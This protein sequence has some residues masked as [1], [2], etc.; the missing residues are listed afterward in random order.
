M[1]NLFVKYGAKIKYKKETLSQDNPKLHKRFGTIKESVSNNSIFDSDK[2]VKDN[3]PD[4]LLQEKAVLDLRKAEASKELHSDEKNVYSEKDYPIDLEIEK[5]VENALAN[6]KSEMHFLSKITSDL[7]KEIN[8]FIMTAKNDFY[9]GK[10][11]GGSYLFSDDAIKHTMAEHGDFLREGLRAQL[12]MTKE[13][14]AR[15]LSAIK[16]NKIPKD[17]QPAK[18]KRGTPSII[19]S[20]E[21]NGY[22]LY[23]EEITESLGQN[24]PS[25][26]IGLT[27]YKAPTLATAAFYT[28]SVQTQPKRQSMM[29]C[30]YHTT[31]SNDLSRGTF[32]SNEKGEPVKL[33]Y[34]MTGNSQ[35]KYDERAGGLIALSSNP[36]NFTANISSIGEGYIV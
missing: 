25:D 29:P 18:T 12:P 3:F 20:Y 22:T 36:S 28:T 27:M 10:Y 26:L 14:I 8:R 31:N 21:V 13:D 17:I 9:R 24:T 1:R 33:C 15:H 4:K 19:T 23:A 7:N 30:E 32:V 2:N 5:M 35:P 6:S 16:D 11:T 34:I